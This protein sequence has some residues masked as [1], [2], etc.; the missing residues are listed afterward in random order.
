[1]TSLGHSPEHEQATFA[2]GSRP[3]RIVDH[4]P[5]LDSQRSEIDDL[6]ASLRDE[7]MPEAARQRLRPFVAMNDVVAHRL[8]R[9]AEIFRRHPVERVQQV[10]VSFEEDRRLGR[11]AHGLA[12]A[13]ISSF[14][15]RKAENPKPAKPIEIDFGF[16]GKRC[17]RIEKSAKDVFF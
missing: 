13:G 1:M 11:N 3:A 4:S 17:H 2:G 10:P 15:C 12:R 6:D 7:L 16:V 8:G 5:S 9:V 14:V